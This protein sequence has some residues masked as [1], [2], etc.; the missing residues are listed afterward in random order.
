MHVSP[1]LQSPPLISG[2][3]GHQCLGS[4]SSSEPVAN[5]ACEPGCPFPQ[6]VA[7]LAKDCTSLRGKPGG[8]LSTALSISARSF[9][10]ADSS[11]SASDSCPGI[12]RGAMTLLHY[13]SSPG[14]VPET[15]GLSTT[16][17]TSTGTALCFCLGG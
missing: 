6:C 3:Q 1:N 10:P 11:R 15:Q 12:G 13:E 5:N 16:A 4:G 7:I 9:P 8:R 17:P 14:H 2:L